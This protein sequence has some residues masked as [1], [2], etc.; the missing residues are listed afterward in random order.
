VEIDWLHVGDARYGG[1][2]LNGARVAFERTLELAHM[3]EAGSIPS[4]HRDV[5]VA[6]NRIGQWYERSG[7]PKRALQSYQQN[8]NIYVQ[9]AA[10]DPGNAMA[11]WD[12]ANASANVGAAMAKT[13]RINDALKMIEQAIQTGEAA[14]AR[15]PANS[16]VRGLLSQYYVIRAQAKER[17]N[18]LSGALSDFQH[19][20]S[21]F[22]TLSTQDP[23]N[24]RGRIDVAAC[25]AG[26]GRI[27]VKARLL[28]QGADSFHKALG[29][30]LPFTIANP[31]HIRALYIVADS[32]VGLGDISAARAASGQEAHW[33][34]ARSYYEKSLAAWRLIRPPFLV[35]IL[36][37]DVGSPKDVVERIAR[38]DRELAKLHSD[39]KFRGAI[40]R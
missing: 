31:P 7:D 39:N 11:Q 38:C 28:D 27:S 35:S 34:E 16:F 6:W 22:Q 24:V 40:R 5:A 33:S 25:A 30:L 2:D 37:F 26:V 13:G 17:A 3:L 32:Q 10:A 21:L 19:A 29:A 20:C 18:L 23:T 36:S 4:R 9:L 12:L 14:A 8:R 15:D 1:G